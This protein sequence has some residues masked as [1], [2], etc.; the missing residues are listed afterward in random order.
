MQ[1]KN[2]H[3]HHQ[4]Q[5]QLQPFSFFPALSIENNETIALNL[6]E[7]IITDIHFLI[8]HLHINSYLIICYMYISYIN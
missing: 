3:H 1:N 7:L 2:P 8:L 6:G 5:Q 4:Q